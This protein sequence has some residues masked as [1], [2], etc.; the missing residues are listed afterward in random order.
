M[1]V[2]NDGRRQCATLTGWSHEYIASS[3]TT[4]VTNN[5]SARMWTERRNTRQMSP[6]YIVDWNAGMNCVELAQ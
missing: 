1:A 3:K 4:S 2:A 5:H 6:V